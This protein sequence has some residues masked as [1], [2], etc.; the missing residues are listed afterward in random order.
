MIIFTEAAIT[1]NDR[2][3]ICLDV[4]LDYGDVDFRAS[5]YKIKPLKGFFKDVAFMRDFKKKLPELVDGDYVTEEHAANVDDIAGFCL[6][7]KDIYTNEAFSGGIDAMT[8][9]NYLKAKKSFYKYN[10][11]ND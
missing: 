7:V 6:I 5:D 8:E 4:Q 11:D 3:A 9:K 1:P 2:W 10:N